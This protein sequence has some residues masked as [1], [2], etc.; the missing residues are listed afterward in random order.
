MTVIH[1]EG[2]EFKVRTFTTIHRGE[3]VKMNNGYICRH[4]GLKVSTD[5]AAAYLEGKPS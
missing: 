1:C 2:H 5:R 4:C 3:E